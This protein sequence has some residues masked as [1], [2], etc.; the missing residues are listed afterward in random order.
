MIKLAGHS[1][2]SSPPSMLRLQESTNELSLSLIGLQRNQSAAWL[3]DSPI[4]D[5]QWVV[6]ND[7]PQ[8]N[9][10]VLGNLPQVTLSGTN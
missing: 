2:F 7:R 1:E 9:A 5:S 3:A 4:R 6:G 10:N 8:E